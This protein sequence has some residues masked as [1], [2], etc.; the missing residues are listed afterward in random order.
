MQ[1]LRLYSVSWIGITS[2]H[3]YISKALNITVYDLLE[4]QDMKIFDKV[5]HQKKHP[6]RN[7]IPKL[8]ALNLVTGR[9]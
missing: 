6:L 7:L 1:S 5:K 4:K 9:N 2:G 8:K 3:T